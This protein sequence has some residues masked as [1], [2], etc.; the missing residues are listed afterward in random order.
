MTSIGIQVH[1]AWQ[2]ADGKGLYEG[3]NAEDPVHVCARLA[4]IHTEVSELVEAHRCEKERAPCDKP[5]L[6]L[7]NEEE[8]LADIVL[9]VFTHAGW[10]GVNLERAI[11]L[12]HEYNK[13]RPH[14]HGGKAF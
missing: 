14:K 5:G 10:R 7:T 11:R 9:R 4:L 2:L 8:D 3:A 13:N 6:D 12:K 1:H